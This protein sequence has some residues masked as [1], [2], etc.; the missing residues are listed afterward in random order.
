[1][2][3]LEIIL[4]WLLDSKK[5]AVLLFLLNTSYKSKQ[6]TAF[7]LPI[8]NLKENIWKLK[9]FPSSNTQETRKGDKCQFYQSAVPTTNWEPNN[10][11]CFWYVT[12]YR[13]RRTYHLVNQSPYQPKRDE[14]ALNKILTFRWPIYQRSQRN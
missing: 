3:T 7:L 5:S 10:F 9:T 14:I 4:K 1:M 2:F 11:A 6:R 8:F 12:S 13:W